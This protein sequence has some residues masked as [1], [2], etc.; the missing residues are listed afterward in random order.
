MIKRPEAIRRRRGQNMIL[1]LII[2]CALFTV[3]T[4][5]AGRGVY[6]RGDDF[7]NAGKWDEAV[8]SFTEALQKEPDNLEYNIRLIMVKERAS[9]YHYQKA[10][11]AVLQD[12][13]DDAIRE[14]QLAST[15]NPANS[16]AD[17]EFKKAVKTKESRSR[18]ELGLELEKQGKFADAIAEFQEAVRIDP[19]NNKAMGAKE[20]ALERQKKAVEEQNIKEKKD[21]PLFSAK[22]ITLQFKDVQIKQAFEI[23]AKTVGL[24]VL[25]DESIKDVKTSL[26]IKDTPFNYALELLLQTNNLFKKQ[27]GDNTILVIPDTPAKKKQYQELVIQTF[28][29]SNSR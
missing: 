27:V 19:R 14:F 13:L 7:A 15:L 18:Y 4:G 29:L 20:T 6:E 9:E 3:L 25:F 21:K 26:F 12:R 17:S 23:L 8:I 2:C 10:T 24:N 11:E 1:L 22:P 5:C 16:A 28:Y